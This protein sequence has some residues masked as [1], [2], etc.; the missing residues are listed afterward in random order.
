MAINIEVGG[1]AYDVSGADSVEFRWVKPDGTTYLTNLT[2]VNAALGEFQMDWS[3]NDSD[4]IGPHLGE[5]VVTTDGVVETYPNDGS[6]II[7]WVSPQ[8]G[9]LVGG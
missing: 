6:K 1:A 4:T 5:V 2:P 7:W 9:D 3:G 8:V